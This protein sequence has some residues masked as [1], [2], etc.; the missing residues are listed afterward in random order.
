MK[1]SY[2]GSEYEKYEAIVWFKI[3]RDL[4]ESI[5]NYLKNGTISLSLPNPIQRNIQSPD[6]FR[7]NT[8]NKYVVRNIFGYYTSAINNRIIANSNSRNIYILDIKYYYHNDF[9]NF[10]VILTIYLM[11]I[12]IYCW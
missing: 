11:I 10:N 5:T 9:F 7:R 2:K 8:C 12:T 1:V 4:E 3:S 6:N